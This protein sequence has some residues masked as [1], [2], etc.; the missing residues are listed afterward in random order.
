[1]S[2][3]DDPLYRKIVEG[4]DTPIMLGI[5]G[6]SGVEGQYLAF[7]A[8]DY[9]LQGE[10][11]ERYI[12]EAFDKAPQVNLFMHERNYR[13]EIGEKSTT[14]VFA[15]GETAAHTAPNFWMEYQAESPEHEAFQDAMKK[16]GVWMFVV[17]TKKSLRQFLVG[18]DGTV[19]HKRKMAMTPELMKTF[20]VGEMT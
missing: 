13:I 7:I 19:L 5:L 17:A 14:M 20:K 9:Y 11:M 4:N 18:A 10:S 1:M 15:E 2:L 8:V 12:E 16:M 3:R 6:V